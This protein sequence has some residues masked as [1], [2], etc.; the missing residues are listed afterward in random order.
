MRARKSNRLNFSK[1][2]IGIGERGKKK[3]K[4][5]FVTNNNKTTAVTKMKKR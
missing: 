1:E 3:K 4:V 2:K 5:G